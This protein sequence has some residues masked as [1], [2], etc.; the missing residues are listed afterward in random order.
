MQGHFLIHMVCLM[1]LLFAVRPPGERYG[2]DEKNDERDHPLALYIGLLTYHLLYALFSFTEAFTSYAKYYR[3]TPAIFIVFTVILMTRIYH[4]WLYRPGENRDTLTSEQ[5]SFEKWL[6]IEILIVIG[7]VISAALFTL[8]RQL[9]NLCNKDEYLI[10]SNAHKYMGQ[11][12]FLTYWTN[13]LGLVALNVQ[14][15]VILCGMHFMP[16]PTEQARKK[17]HFKIDWLE[18]SIFG[19]CCLQSFTLLIGL[20]ISARNRKSSFFKRCCKGK[21]MPFVKRTLVN[22]S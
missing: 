7:Q 3:F 11:S 4:Q 16:Y 15:C 20:F 22:V 9:L 13:H 6:W 12:D 10:I 21:H 8:F 1:T 17:E 18:G 14:P 19:L 2:D 5:H